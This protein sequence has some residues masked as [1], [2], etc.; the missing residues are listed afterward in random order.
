MHKFR[1]ITLPLVSPTTFFVLIMSL[2]WAFQVFEEAYV[3]TRGGPAF[4]TTT[5]VY[6]IYMS[7]F[8][9]F[10]MGD[11][12]AVAWILF[13]MI[14]VVTLMQVRLQRRWVHYEAEK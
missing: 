13:A 12:A 8:Q 7:G 1:H 2:I 3:M 11:A 14:F 10:R 9:W 5:V 4:A 6:Y